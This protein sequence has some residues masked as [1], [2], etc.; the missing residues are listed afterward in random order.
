MQNF[1]LHFCPQ[2]IIRRVIPHVCLKKFLTDKNSG[3]LKLKK[4]E[5]KGMKV[6]NVLLSKE[7]F[8]VEKLHTTQTIN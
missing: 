5:P 8:D 3:V 2:N 1:F 7:N 4:Y 6:V